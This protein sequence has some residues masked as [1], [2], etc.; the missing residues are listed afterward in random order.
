M[1]TYVESSCPLGLRDMV[2]DLIV[3]CHNATDLL[4]D[5][6]VHSEE[7]MHEFMDYCV[8]VPEVLNI[9]KDWKAS[10][11]LRQLQSQ[12]PALLPVLCKVYRVPSS[13]S[14]VD[15]IKKKNKRVL[16]PLRW[17]LND[18]IVEK[19]VSIAHN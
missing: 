5:E 9:R 2:H 16:N 8:K 17:W 11:L 4:K 13:N 6:D 18:D 7:F 19:H 1:S 12:Y 3:G 14:G 15:E 10:M